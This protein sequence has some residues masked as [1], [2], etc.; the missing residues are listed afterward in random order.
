MGNG[1]KNNQESIRGILSATN[2]TVGLNDNEITALISVAEFRIYKRGTPIILE[3]S[4]SRDLYVI[5]EGRASVRISLPS[6]EEREEIVYTM[7]EGQVFGELSLVDGSP[8]SATVRAEDD[9]SAFVFDFNKLNNLLENQ[10]RIGYFLMRNIAAII[11]NRMRNT[12]MLWRNSI[13]W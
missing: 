7:R 10:P 9:V 5:S 4:K 6:D 1:S 8:R 13:I 3:D 2:L 12:N 11:S